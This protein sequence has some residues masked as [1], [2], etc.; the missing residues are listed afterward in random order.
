MG[1]WV[2]PRSP[3]AFESGAGILSEI[4]R[5]LSIM[6]A[7][8]WTKNFGAG[9]HPGSRRQSTSIKW[10]SLG[11][12]DWFLPPTLNA[13]CRRLSNVLMR[14]LEGIKRSA[15]WDRPTSAQRV[16]TSAPDKVSLPP[17]A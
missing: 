1:A 15:G 13:R 11:H 3:G 17:H 14:L 4:D 5:A 16:F 9:A 8:H 7:A 6:G 12:K 10:H 2:G